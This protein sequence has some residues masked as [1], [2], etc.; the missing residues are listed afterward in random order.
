[1]LFKNI[2]ILAELGCLNPPG[3]PA[4]RADELSTYELKT[5]DGGLW[6][7]NLHNHVSNASAV[8]YESS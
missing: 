5:G 4:E 8:T 6:H 7:P 3:N 1:M 2:N